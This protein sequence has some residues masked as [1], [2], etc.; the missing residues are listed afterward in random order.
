LVLGELPFG[1]LEL[2][3][4]WPGI[5]VDKVLTLA[6]ELALLE[7]DSRDLTVYT[8]ANG[9]GIKCGDR[10][11]AVKVHREITTLSGCYNNRY[12][13]SACSLAALPFAGPSGAAWSLRF[14]ACA[15]SAEVPKA[16]GNENGQS[17]DPHPAVAL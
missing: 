16:H 9:Y 4:K 3:L 8:A 15:R 7:V 11:K 1:L 14:C 13:E 12:Y 10:T 2:N 17:D 6:D 5:D